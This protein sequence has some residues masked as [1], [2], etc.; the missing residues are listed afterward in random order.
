MSI[1]WSSDWTNAPKDGE[2]K[3]LLLLP[4]GDISTGC[5]YWYTESDHES[6]MEPIAYW[7]LQDIVR[8]VPLDDTGPIEG[9]NIKWAVFP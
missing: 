2:T 8:D 9:S 4:T 7:S 1:Q 3:I 6:F 5:F